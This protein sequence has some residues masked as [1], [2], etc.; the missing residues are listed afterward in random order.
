[1]GLLSLA[2]RYCG[3]DPAGGMDVCLLRELCVVRWSLRRADH[4][5]EGVPPT[6]VCRCVWSRNL[7]NQEA[8]ARVGP[9]HHRKK[10]GLYNF[11]DHE[12]YLTELETI[13]GTERTEE[14][15]MIDKIIL[16]NEI[17]MPIMQFSVTLYVQ[18]EVSCT[19]RMSMGSC[20]PPTW[21]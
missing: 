4:S 16:W 8:L 13:N 12:R 5:S 9:Q 2:C 14:E 11:R 17:K 19:S 6:V 21:T 20:Y 7:K 18:R 1:M 10:N 3:F 15:R